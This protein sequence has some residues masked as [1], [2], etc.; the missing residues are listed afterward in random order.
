ML[1]GIVWYTFSS[2]SE[3]KSVDIYDTDSIILNLKHI[4][5]ETLLN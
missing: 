2:V 3:I 5:L 1:A 4:S